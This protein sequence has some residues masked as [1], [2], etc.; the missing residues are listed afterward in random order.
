MSVTSAMQTGVS[1]LLTNGEAISVIG[2]NLANVNTT[3]FKE[4]RTLFS[5]MLSTSINKGQVGH[6]SQIQSVEN[7]FSQ[8][9]LENTS[10]ATDL[11]IQGDG[12]FALQ[13]P[14]SPERYYSRAG[15]FNFD[16]SNILTNPDGYKVLGYGI[17]NGASN[18]I[19]GTINLASFVNMAPKATT[20][21]TL[22]ANLDS[23]QSI[24]AA[25]WNP[26]LAN[27]NPVAASNFSTSTTAYDAKGNATPLT[28][29]FAKTAPDAWSVYAYDGTT[30][31]ANGAGVPITFDAVN[32]TLATINAL[33]I[34]PATFPV[35][36]VGNA[37]T[38]DIAGTTQFNASSAI[39]SLNQD[40]YAAGD[41][42]KV[43]IDDKG[44]VNILY[45][46]NQTQKAAQVALAKFAATTG[47]DKEGGSLF[48]ET[49]LSGTAVIDPANLS[50]NKITSFAL[51]QS[52]V[53][54]AD[55]LVKM[56]TTQRAYSANSKTITTADQLMQD[57]LNI[58]R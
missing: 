44:F 16:N 2:N 47:L 3:G 9:S 57:T 30:Y 34:P 4:G 6:G 8:G 46:N 53:D 5:D 28:L 37:L 41:L 38:V 55:Q 29:Y 27:F 32:G 35:P 26:L 25:V 22:S 13:G 1:G 48:R 58:I 21:I 43:S 10:S 20:Q 18:G 42:T 14:N 54:M 24:P 31:T 36:I 39:S 56:I 23:S 50:T 15:A 52:N 45:S 49:A 51:E 19:L 11:A 17:A 33:A 7:I 12:F 40:G